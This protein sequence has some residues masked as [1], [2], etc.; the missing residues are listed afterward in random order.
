MS[1]PTGGASDAALILVEHANQ[2]T[3]I[4]LAEP[5]LVVGD[6]LVWGPNPLF[7]KADATDTV[8]YPCGRQDLEGRDAMKFVDE[9][10]LSWT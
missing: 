5:G 8:A 7:D 3:E 9:A 2:L 1:T 6:M 10:C 4:D